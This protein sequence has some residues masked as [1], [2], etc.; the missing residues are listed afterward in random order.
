MEIEP[1]HLKQLSRDINST[2]GTH[3]GEFRKAAT[4]G[5]KNIG[6]I[7]KDISKMFSSQKRDMG[8]FHETLEETN[9]ATQRTATKIDNTNSILQESVALQNSILSEMKG[10]NGA[11]RM[12]N[13]NIQNMNPNSIFDTIFTKSPLGKVLTGLE[14]ALGAGAIGLAG[15]TGYQNVQDAEKKNAETIA[16]LGG[17]VKGKGTANFQSVAPRLM[18]D[19]QKDFPGMSK[20]DA[21]AIIGNLSE[22]SGGFTKMKEGGGGPGRGWAQWTSADRKQKFLA[23]VQ[24]Y[25]NGDLENYQANYETLKSELKNEYAGVL[26]QMMATQGAGNKARVFMEKFENPNRALAHMD[27][28][29]NETQR[30]LN[31]SNVGNAVAQDASPQSKPEAMTSGAAS[32]GGDNA[33]SDATAAMPQR[34]NGIIS[35]AMGGGTSEVGKG[36][37]NGEQGKLGTVNPGILA[38]FKDIQSQAGTPL[39]VTSGFRDPQ[40]NAEV[41]GAKNSAHTRGNAVD[42]TFGGGVPEALKLIETASKAG[43][44]GIGVYSPNKLH[45]DTEAKRSWGPDY[46]RGS[47]PSWAEKAI[48]AH[49]S[50]TGSSGEANKGETTPG[51][52]KSDATPQT[53]APVTPNMNNT[54]SQDQQSPPQAPDSEQYGN[55]EQQKSFFQGLAGMGGGG[56]GGMG[57][58]TG[59]MGGMGG[60]G[61]PAGMMGMMGGMGGM[62]GGMGGML[63]MLGPLLGGMGGMGGGMGGMAKLINGG[64]QQASMNTAQLNAAEIEKQLNESSTKQALINHFNSQNKNSDE[65]AVV[66]GNTGQLTVNDY[67]GPEDLGWPDW[68]KMLGGNHYEE[69]KKIKL[70]MWG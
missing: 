47:V 16:S 36:D 42:V 63:G 64:D 46:H 28:R 24:K 25:G 5:N 67:N 51:S 26:K 27:V 39:N 13:A 18:A 12:L 52:G 6:S 40:H 45:F 60:M 8:N 1:Q 17:D 68:A 30:A 69:L 65:A 7:A 58:M 3:L 56:M 44:G 37:K 49:L 31:L 62:G 66:Q 59:M 70:N 14:V 2:L 9:Q 38:K 61:M 33:G 48:Q 21:A 57:G 43:I 11:F 53:T 19:L 15:Y 20:E 22:E 34:H 35:G 41:G 23:N 4:D 54:V 50:G 10:M 29:L 32:S 55:A